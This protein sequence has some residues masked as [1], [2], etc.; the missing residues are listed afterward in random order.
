MEESKKVT[1]QMRGL[2]LINK[3]VLSEIKGR[4]TFVDNDFLGALY[5]HE[6]LFKEA[7][8]LFSIITYVSITLFNLSFCETCSSLT[9]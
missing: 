1:Y 5:H 7:L 3:E 2:I 4:Y 9:K 8:V 6:E